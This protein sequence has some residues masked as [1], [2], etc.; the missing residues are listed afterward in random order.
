MCATDRLH[1]RFREAEVLDLFLLN[2]LTYC[3]G[4]LFDR[5]VRVDA[6]LEEKVDRLDA[7]P[8]ERSVD[9]P[10]GR[11]RPTVEIAGPRRIDR[12]AA[13]ALS[14]PKQCSTT[15]GFGAKF[16]KDMSAFCDA[17]TSGATGAAPLVC[18]IAGSVH[19]PK[20]VLHG[21]FG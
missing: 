20:R 21:L 8:F 6:V 5:H 4:H 13:R 15:S 18:V 14:Y 11:L 19:C 1:A 2:Q 9:A 16:F 17:C 12:V 10:P 3:P 7:E